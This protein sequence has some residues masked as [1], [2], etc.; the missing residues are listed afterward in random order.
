MPSVLITGANRGLGLEFAR[1][2]LA[3]GWEVSAACRNPGSAS[4][5]RQLAE[6]SGGRLRLAMDVTDT[7]SVKAGSSTRRASYPRT[8]LASHNSG[9]IGPHGQGITRPATSDS[10]RRTSPLAVKRA[11]AEADALSIQ[12]EN[13]PYIFFSEHAFFAASHVPPAFSQSAAFFAV[14]TSPAKAGPVKASA[15]ANANVDTSVFMDV[16][17]YGCRGCEENSVPTPLVPCKFIG[18]CAAYLDKAIHSISTALV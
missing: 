6:D 18:P 14:V 11:P 5:L 9:I 4:E 2:Y 8:T 17:P 12:T 13:A 7:G 1:Q 3:D 15:K 10:G 16:T